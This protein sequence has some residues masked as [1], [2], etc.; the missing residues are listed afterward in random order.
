LRSESVRLAIHTEYIIDRYIL[1]R[2]GLCTRF[3]DQYKLVI[4]VAE[5][6]AGEAIAKIRQGICPFCGKRFG[7]SGIATHLK[8]TVWRTLKVH[9]YGSEWFWAHEIYPKNPCVFKYAKLVE[10]IANAYVLFRSA[11]RRT[12]V[13]K[14]RLEVDG[15]VYR[16]R[17]V[18]EVVQFIRKNPEVVYK[19][20]EGVGHA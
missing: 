1:R 5:V 3:Y 10:Y 19:V 2:K 4:A 14:Y 16:F 15:K 11:V 8:N 6:V 7:R 17:N 9:P 20:I 12:T 18:E 13:G